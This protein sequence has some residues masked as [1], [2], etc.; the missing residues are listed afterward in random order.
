[1]LLF[2]SPTT[3]RTKRKRRQWQTR[4]GRG[5]GGR[6]HREEGGKATTANLY[7][8]GDVAATTNLN[9]GGDEWRR[10]DLD[11]GG[12]TG[13][14]SDLDKVG[15]AAAAARG[16]GRRGRR[17]VRR[18]RWIWTK[19]CNADGKSGRRDATVE[20]GRNEEGEWSHW[21]E[22]EKEKKKELGLKN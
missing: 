16:S 11:G 9:E 4:R 7:E 20:G 5:R 19:R 10:A 15:D 22:K 6:G 12:D 3:R 17:G 1:M 14:R 21:M 8:E 18:R 13:Q 2:S